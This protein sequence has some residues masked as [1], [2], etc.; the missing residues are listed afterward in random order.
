MRSKLCGDHGAHPQERGPLGRPVPAGAGAVLPPG[1]DDQGHALVGV[2]HRRFVNRRLGPVGQVQRVPALGAGSQTVPEPD[3]G[4]G[5][6]HH[7]LVVAP[8]GA[9]GVEVVPGHPVLGQ[10]AA[11]GRVRPDGAGRRDVV[12]RDAVAHHGQH[13]GALDVGDRRRRHGH[14]FEEG[15]VLHVRG[16]VLPGER[17]A[18]GHRHL[19]PVLVTLEHGAV[20][21]AEHL[22]GQRGPDGL[23]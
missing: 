18:L 14:A 4:E 3:V 16:V 20:A 10:V 19:P 7:D 15:R 22:R 23:G 13:A 5:A 12:G 1:Q 2:L 17:L 6:A 8:P 9:V 21:G 11:C